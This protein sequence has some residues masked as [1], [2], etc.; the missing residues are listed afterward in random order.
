MPIRWRLSVLAVQVIIL[1]AATYVVTG[2]PFS[3]EIWFF[4]GLLAAIINPQLLE[5]YYP[6]P[7]DI[8]GNSVIFFFIY[9]NTNKTVTH[10]GWNILACFI[11]LFFIL[12]LTAII[13]GAGK[14]EGRFIGL[15]RAARN[16]SQVASSRLIYSSIFF[17]SVVDFDRSF[18]FNFWTLILAWFLIIGIG[19]INWRNIFLTATRQTTTAS[20]EGM[21]GPS[22][23]LI[24]APEIPPPGTRVSISTSN[25]NSEGVVIS[26]IRRLGDVWGQIH[27]IDSKLCERILQGQTI[28]V[29]QSP[30]DDSERQDFVG[31]VDAGSTDRLLRFTATTPLEIGQVVEV[32]SYESSSHIFYQLSSA[33]IERLD[34]KGGAHLVVRAKANQLGIFDTESFWFRSHRWVPFPGA[35]VHKGFTKNNFASLRYPPNL[36]L[37]GH[38]IG[39]SIPVFLDLNAACEGHLAILGMTK[40]GKSTLAER[41]A[42]HLAESRRVTI[43]DQTGEYVNKKKF[44]PCDEKVDWKKPG[45]AVFEPKPGEIPAQR[46]HDFLNYQV[47]QALEE[48]KQGNPIPRSVIIDEAHQFIP[49]P[50]GLGFGAPGRNQSYAF[51]LL[52]MQIRKYGISVILISQRTAVVAK[53]ALSQ[54]ENLIAFRSVDQ[55]GLDYLEAVAGS[56]VRNFLPQLR[57]GEALVFGQA[58]SSDTPVGI[59]VYKET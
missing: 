46:A 4:A 13:A 50:A 15:A 6:R 39:T 57:Q 58:I 38:V 53:S 32:P 20:A 45:I 10:E 56:D 43:L 16:V 49:E 2:K 47:T 12:G 31:T 35:L 11:I 59:T 33:N 25:V 37:L 41:I 40:M 29:K 30:D 44:P 26:R 18:S 24:S 48:Y 51:G 7:A 1:M 42:R 36:M 14:K 3:S 28:V 52:M 55:T 5:P 19:K 54:C 17:L 8:I 21:I 23:I 34:V 22:S 9:L 27:V